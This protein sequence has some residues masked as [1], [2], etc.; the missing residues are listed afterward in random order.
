M[1]SVLFVCGIVSLYLIFKIL[2]LVRSYKNTPRFLLKVFKVLL[3]TILPAVR[4]TWRGVYIV[5]S[6]NL[7]LLYSGRR[8]SSQPSCRGVSIDEDLLGT[9]GALVHF[10]FPCSNFTPSLFSWSCLSSRA[11]PPPFFLFFKIV[12]VWCLSLSHM[13]LR[14]PSMKTFLWWSSRTEFID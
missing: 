6:R 1:Q 8:F 11:N 4:L 12:P 7:I 13:H 3:C 2:P 10:F 5:R 14:V 9:L